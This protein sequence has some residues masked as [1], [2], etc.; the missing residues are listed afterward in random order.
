MIRKA[1]IPAAGLGTRMLPIT[2]SMPK[3][4][5]PIVDRPVIHYVV[6]EAVKAGIED[7]LIITGKGKRAIED[8]FD[9]S[10]E[11]E[12]YLKE[13]G[14]LE[15]LREVEEIG[16]MVDIYY[17]RQKKP[18]GLGDA[19]LYAEKHVNGEPFA[20][21]LGDDII[22]SKKPAIKQLIEVAE[23]KN[24]PVIGV[25]SVP[26]ELVSR[27]G[28]I[29]GELIEND[30][31]RI[32]RLVE[33]PSPKEAPS[34]IAII[35]RYILIPEIFD[36]LRETPPGRDGEIQLTDALQILLNKNEILAK[37]IEGERY[38]IG[39]KF[40]FVMANLKLSLRREELRNEVLKY[41]KSI[42]KEIS[43]E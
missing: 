3:E 20:V 4:M 8:Y 27:Y 35:G 25:E 43:N 7:I 23:R 39:S 38:D 13:R 17:V 33:K 31:Y 14:K 2:K 16:E 42:L 37:R 30:L 10:F 6:E 19:I 41:L 34:N 5:L 21:L 11:L 32:K 18:L 26:R 12:Y 15:A 28:I 29:E 40:G 36:I 1:V 22:I 24:T 9:R